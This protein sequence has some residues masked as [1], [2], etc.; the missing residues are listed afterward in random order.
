[1]PIRP[2]TSY[3]T[4][5]DGVRFYTRR[6]VP[7]SPRG[8]L[9]VVHGLGEH[10]GRYDHFIDY[11]GSRGFAISMYDQRGH[12]R[13]DGKHGHVDKFEQ[14]TDDVHTHIVDSK[15]MVP[16]NA[17]CIVVGHS[18]GGLIVLNYI[19][20]YDDG[21]RA[22]I[23]SSPAI[24]PTVKVP[25][26]VRWLG[27]RAANFIPRFTIAASI[28]AS[29]LS[30]DTAVV[31]Q[32]RNDPLVV[33]RIT[34]KAGKEILQGA[35][36]SSNLAYN[37][38]CPLLMIQ[39]RGDK[40]CSAD[41]TESFFNNVLHPNKKLMIYEG[42]FHEPFNDV[43]RERVFAD[44]EEW[45]GGVLKTP[46]ETKLDISPYVIPHAESHPVTTGAP[47]SFIEFT[48]ANRTGKR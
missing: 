27:E 6:H 44:V 22:A 21:I 31:R 20:T 17:P 13:T 47:Q 5:R 14:W 25:A 32:Y 10:S 1:M 36:T 11:F 28:D 4:N 2:V 3:F 9:V 15:K 12:G 39:G 30:R 45:L 40:I 37:V 16:T 43:I 29:Y 48:V 26:L 23:V 35:A 38:K 8:L 33:K 19:T 46:F 18:L 7:T 41:A 24:T 42:D 34:L